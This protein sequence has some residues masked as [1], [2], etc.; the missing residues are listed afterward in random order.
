MNIPSHFCSFYLLSKGLSL[1]NK[2]VLIV[3]GGGITL[4]YIL[5]ISPFNCNIEVLRRSSSPIVVPALSPE[6]SSKIKTSESTPENL[7]AALPSADIVMIAAALTPSTRGMFG[8]DQFKAMK[9]DA[10]LVN[11]AR[12]EL[13]KTGDLVEALKDDLIGGAGIDV[14]D[15]EPLPESHKLWS[16]KDKNLV[17][18]PHTADTF[19]MVVPLLSEVSLFL[20]ISSC[21]VQ[22]ENKRSHRYR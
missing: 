12:G 13:V 16:M 21:C 4:S 1:F 2:N 14:T 10:V 7:M 11:V 20:R 6:L 18:T 8:L 15:P 22:E 9:K 3:G 5:Q 17:I 19:D